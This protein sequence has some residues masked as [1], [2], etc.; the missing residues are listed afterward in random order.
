MSTGKEQWGTRVGVIL[1]VAGSAVGLGNFLR[2]PGQAAQYGGGAFMIPYFI[3]LLVLGLPLVWAEWTMGRY[4]GKF[5]ANSCP[6]IFGILGG[7]KGWRYAGV[8]GVL[9]PVVIYMYYVLIE[10]W[11]LGYAWQYLVVGMELGENKEQYAEGAKTFFGDFVGANANGD[12]FGGTSY[13]IYFFLFTFALN[14]VLIY[15][16]LSKGIEAFCIRAMPIMAALAFIILIRVLTLGANESDPEHLNINNG[17]GYMWNP[18]SRAEGQ[19]WYYALIDGEVW[20]AAA[21]QIFFSLSIGFGVIVN[22]A[23]YLK[24]KDDIALSGLTAASTNEFFEVALGGLITIPAAFYFFGALDPGTLDSS[25]ALGFRTLPAVFETMPFSWFF[26]FAFF[27]MLFLAA[28]TS[29]LSMLQPAIAFLEEGLNIGRRAS[30][31]IL[32]M[33]TG[34]GSLFVIIF[35]E[36]LVAL[37][38]MDFWIGTFLIFILS[39][40][41]VIL[42]AW[43][44]GA[45][46]GYEEAMEGAEIRIPHLW[47]WMIQFITPLFLLVIFVVFAIQKLP[48]RLKALSGDWVGIATVFFIVAVAVGLTVLT[49][50]SSG[51][52]DRRGFTTPA[53]SGEAE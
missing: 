53:E 45:E 8:I 39:T 50:I 27:F 18:R 26:G 9:I 5:G 28:I 34:I 23:S 41:Q 1:A 15:R 6:A 42:F 19:D 21:G 24:K 49:A 43:V 10:S 47:R 7:H 44:F 35:S 37:D 29:S 17:L 31:T 46:K 51:N 2:F 32:G 30:V 12:A 25:F 40:I 14:F 48:D 36:G 13:A 20:L 38:T 16:G 33:I 3:S 22:Y 11:C 4:G 52:W